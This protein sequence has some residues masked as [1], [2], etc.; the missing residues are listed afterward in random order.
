MDRTD[1]PRALDASKP[2]TVA[3]ITTRFSTG[4]AELNALMLA[5]GFRSLGMRSELWA[6]YRAGDLDTGAIPSRVMLNRPPRGAKDLWAMACGLHRAVR[7]F[8][9]DVILGFQPLANI[10]ASLRMAFSGRFVASQRNPAHSQS[11]LMRHIEGLVG[12]TPLYHANI[13]VSESVLNS[14]SGYLA[15]YR[16]KMTV[17]HN[18]LPPLPAITDDKVTARRRLGLPEAVPLVGAIGR[19]HVQKNQIFLL[20]VMSIL[21]GVHLMLAGDGPD[22]AMLR[23]AVASRGIS[24]R[25][26]FIGRIDGEDVPRAYKALDVFLFPSLFE[27][28]GRSLIEA[29]ALNVPMVVHDLPVTREVTDGIPPLLPLDPAAWAKAIETCLRGNSYDLA[30]AR[31]RAEAFGLQKMI[32]S[33]AHVIASR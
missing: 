22:E 5:D 12:S 24:D 14:Y 9:P 3:C 31:A 4:G 33:Y 18:G 28:F 21:P 17:I 10:M 7:D 30:D 19:L 11:I 16:A 13:A 26:H 25:V 27:G 6:L 29:M 8:A 15:P 20:D 1:P 2:L 32:D 23:A